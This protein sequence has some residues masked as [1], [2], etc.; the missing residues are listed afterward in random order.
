MLFLFHISGR[1]LYTP[2]C[3]VA[4]PLHLEGLTICGDH[5]VANGVVCTLYGYRIRDLQNRFAEQY[6]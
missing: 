5:Y 6:I 3:N 4:I 2:H 1:S